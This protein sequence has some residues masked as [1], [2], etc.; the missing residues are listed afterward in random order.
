MKSGQITCACGLVM[1]I[2]TL[3]NKIECIQCKTIHDISH[4]QEAV[5]FEEVPKI[6]PYAE[7]IA[8]MAKITDLL[9]KEDENESF[10]G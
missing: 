4:F 7:V 10:L 2:E 1:G 6:D 3:S 9:P 5:I 8:L